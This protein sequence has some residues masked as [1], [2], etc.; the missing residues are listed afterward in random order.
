MADAPVSP[1]GRGAPPAARRPARGRC[2]PGADRA[3]GERARRQRRTTPLLADRDAVTAGH[4]DAGEEGRRRSRAR[5]PV[6]RPR[7]PGSP[8][9]VEKAAPAN[10][11]RGR[12]RTPRR[13]GNRAAKKTAGREAPPAPAAARRA[14]RS[15]G[16][17]ALAAREGGR[18]PPRSRRR[19]PEPELAGTEPAPPAREAGLGG[20]RPSASTVSAACPASAR[21]S[22]WRGHRLAGGGDAR[23]RR[24]PSSRRTAEAEAGVAAALDFLRA[25]ADRR[26]RGRR[27]RLRR[28]VH[29][30]RL[31]RRCCARSTGAGSGS[32][33]G[34]SRTSRRPAARWSSRTTP[35]PCPWTR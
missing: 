24:W 20:A 3:S 9:A 33:C 35:A 16:K 26:V 30:Q 14:P 13:R 10:K 23:R 19:P 12:R 5:P 11:R 8:R 18:E 2:W 34:A 6:R 15:R 29:R 4:G 21:S 25:P 17:Q 1:H 32:R 28:G 31:A 7:R 22:S 27:V